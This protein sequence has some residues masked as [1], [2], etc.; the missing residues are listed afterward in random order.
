[1]PRIV[2]LLTF[3]VAAA[4]AAPAPAQCVNRTALR[5]RF[6][7]APAP[8]LGGSVA[9]TRG[10]RYFADADFDFG[11]FACP[12]QNSSPAVSY[13]ENTSLNLFGS[14]FSYG[15]RSLASA[16][17]WAFILVDLTTPT[18]SFTLGSS[19][20][21]SG[22]AAILPAIAPR[23]ETFTAGTLQ[24]GFSTLTIRPRVTFTV[25]P[26]TSFQAVG[27]SRSANLVITTGLETALAYSQRVFLFGLPVDATLSGKAQDVFV[28]G[29]TSATSSA[30]AAAVRGS[31]TLR[32]DGS[33]LSFRVTFAGLNL[34]NI[35][36]SRPS[37]SLPS[38]TF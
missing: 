28:N 29:F 35:N 36:W 23:S 38:V 19:V 34:I 15:Y 1:M 37:G 2:P 21:A 33:N 6:A 7:E 22:I 25:D 12:N 24:I 32:D 14:P 13:S 8:A 10:N 26:T 3:L 18:G 30:T 31:Y 20:G 11:G 16:G 17:G 27:R 5:T 4:A 9:Y